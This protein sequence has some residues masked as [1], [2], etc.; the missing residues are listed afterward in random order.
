MKLVSG[1]TQVELRDSFTE[2]PLVIVS[3][4]DG[5]LILESF[6]NDAEMDTVR[7]ALARLR[8]RK[9]DRTLP[10][11]A[12][13]WVKL[14]AQALDVDD[15]QLTD[16]WEGYNGETSEQLMERAT[17]VLEYDDS[18]EWIQKKA[19]RMN[20][21]HRASGADPEDLD[22]IERIAK[23]GYYGMWGFERPKDERWHAVDQNDMLVLATP[24]ADL[25]V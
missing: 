20:K 4:L 25:A 11:V 6:F 21:P 1:E 7:K 24:F 15:V 22:F 13:E 16:M 17:D 10:G 19:R 23:G 12:M 2:E 9:P 8:A 14:V 5:S 3:T 18:D